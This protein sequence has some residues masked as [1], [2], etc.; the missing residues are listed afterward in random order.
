[1][2]KKQLRDEYFPRPKKA[3]PVD[4]AKVEDTKATE[5]FEPFYEGEQDT[6]R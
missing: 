6:G 2:I 1:M 5:K 4:A 3:Q